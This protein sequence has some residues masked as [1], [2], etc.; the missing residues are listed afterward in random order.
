MKRN[1][2]TA[3]R[4]NVLANQTLCMVMRLQ[5]EGN[6]VV[7]ANQTCDWVICAERI[8][9]HVDGVVNAVVLTERYVKIII[10]G[11]NSVL[12]FGSKV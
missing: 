1:Y 7:R 11:W 10:C 2:T 12:P 5:S 6:I 3:I 8:E 4:Q 9:L